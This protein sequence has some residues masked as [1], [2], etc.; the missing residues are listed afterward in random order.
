LIELIKRVEGHRL[1]IVVCL[2]VLLGLRRE[3]ICGLQWSNVHFDKRVI[4]IKEA[5]TM[6]GSTVIDKTPK[7]KTSSRS[8]YITDDL[9]AILNEEKQK[10]LEQAKTLGP[11]Y[12]NSDFV[13]CWEDG[14]PYRP[15]YLSELFTKFITDQG[16]PKI[17]LHGLR[18]SFVTL[19]NSAGETLYNLSKVVGHSTPDV[20]GRIY[21]HLD[22]DTHKDLLKNLTNSF[23]RKNDK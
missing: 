20:T 3:E 1:K 6:A 8:L 13:V 11:A 7:N 2:A 12:N 5:K 23:F 21:S 16:L 17:T 22:D 15:N 14:N 19:G 10:Q 18:H 4:I 9:L